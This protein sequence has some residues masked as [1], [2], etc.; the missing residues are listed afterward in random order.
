MKEI[1]LDRKYK[2][3]IVHCKRQSYDVYIGRPTIYKNPFFIGKDGNRQEV[4]EKFKAYFLNRIVTDSQFKSAIRK[5]NGKVLGCWCYPKDCHGRI[6]MEY[7][8][9]IS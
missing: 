1:Y 4:I 5:L 9:D 8:E 3:K 7:L 6:I 2:D